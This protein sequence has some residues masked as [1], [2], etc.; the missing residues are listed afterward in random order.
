MQNL[1]RH[2]GGIINSGTLT[3]VSST[4]DSNRLTGDGL[5]FGGG[6]YNKGNLTIQSSTLSR[7]V[8]I[9]GAGLFIESGFSTI[10]NSTMSGNTTAGSGGAV[11]AFVGGA[12]IN[13]STIT[14]NTSGLTINSDRGPTI[15]V[16]SSV[17]AGNLENDVEYILG[18]TNT[19]KSNGHNIV[20]TG[21]AIAKFVGAGDQIGVTNPLLAPLADDGGPTKTHALLPGSPAIN[22]GDLSLVAGMNGVPQYDQRGEP[23]GRVFNGRIDIGA[24]EYQEPSDLNLIVD[25]L[26]DEADGNY[27]KG[28]LSLREAILLANTYAGPNYPNVSDTIRFDPALTANG[29]ATIVLSLGELAIQGAT[30]I[31]GPG[32]NLLT[33][34][35]SGNDTTPGVFDGKGTRIFNITDSTSGILIVSISGLRLTGADGNGAISSSEDLRL[36]DVVLEQNGGELSVLQSTGKLTLDHSRIVNNTVRSPL[37]GGSAMNCTSLV[38]RDTEVSFNTGGGITAGLEKAGSIVIV[39]SSI[40]DNSRNGVTVK[41]SGGSFQLL[42]SEISANLGVLGSGLAFT[43]FGQVLISDSTFARNVAASG[44][45]QTGGGGAYIGTSTEGSSVRIERSLFVDNRSATGGGGLFVQGSVAIVDSEFRGNLAGQNGGGLLLGNTGQAIADYVVN[46][47]VFA[48]NVATNGAGAYFTVARGNATLSNNQFIGNSA[49]SQGGGL[50]ISATGEGVATITGTS[51]LRNHSLF[52]G[53]ASITTD[54][55]AR[56][57]VE[58]STFA[59]NSARQEGGGGATLI[60]RGSSEISLVQTTV[61]GNTATG[62]G[63]GLSINA[64]SGAVNVA[65]STITL[66]GFSAVPASS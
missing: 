25:T 51:F 43:G 27:A 35:A 44:T 7:N 22:A 12:S 9:K 13:N 41:A 23:F 56:V 11:Y 37:S 50:A 65:H 6:I 59:A 34:D 28:D 63:S 30:N 17:V 46:G 52:G 10:S 53:G 8:A 64:N 39:D 4:I 18:T 47:T 21:N 62:V 24:F 16:R 31:M 36:A 38:M 20:G 45:A 40:S 19:F 61:S 57:R 58:N 2:G 26:V 14:H 29:P 3:I 15:Q 32:S 66:N 33:V 1:A 49:D 60:S 55:S 48:D 5:P 42:R 54:G